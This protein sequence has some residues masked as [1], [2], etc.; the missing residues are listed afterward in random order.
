[1]KI[2][3]TLGLILVFGLLLSSASAQ[4]QKPE[5]YVQTRHSGS[6]NSTTVSK[7]GKIIATAGEDRT[8]KLFDGSNGAEIRT[9]TGHHGAVMAVAFSPDDKV[10]AT[11]GLDGTV[12][13]WDVVT[14]KEMSSPKERFDK[15]A[16]L[17]FSHDGKFLAIGAW[18]GVTLWDL[19]TNKQKFVQGIGGLETCCSVTGVAFTADSKTLVVV[20][21]RYDE[22]FIYLVNLEGELVYD[23][24]SRNQPRDISVYYLHQTKTIV[25]RR[26]RENAQTNE[27]KEMISALEFH[28]DYPP[29]FRKLTETENSYFKNSVF[30]KLAGKIYAN[31]KRISSIYLEPSG[32]FV[33][34]ER[35]DNTFVVWDLTKGDLPKQ[36]NDHIFS[37]PI[38]TADKSADENLQ[39]SLKNQELFINGENQSQWMFQK[40]NFS[41]YTTYFTALAPEGDKLAVFSI[42]KALHSRQAVIELYE[43]EKSSNPN[44]H[45]L[46]LKSSSIALDFEVEIQNSINAKERE[47]LSVVD[48]ISA[49]A[50]RFKDR[51]RMWRNEPRT[52][53][54]KWQAKL[55]ED[56]AIKIINPQTNTELCSLISFEQTDWAV[57]TPQ[58][59][60]DGSPNAWKQLI[61]RLDNNTFNYAPVEAFFKEFYYPG[62]LQEI[63]QGQTPQP[64]AKDL[65]EIDIRQPVVKITE[66]D[67]KPE[68]SANN[69]SADKQT[70]KVR[71]EIED[72]SKA[73]R[74]RDFPASSGANDL[75]LFRNGSLVKLWR[76]ETGDKRANASVFDLAEK[77]G[78]RQITAAKDRS[79]AAVCETEVSIVAG[80]NTFTAYAFNHDNIKSNDATLSVKRADAL[81]RPATLHVLAI[82][83]KDYSNPAFNLKYSVADAEALAAEIQKQQKTLPNFAEVKVTSLFDAQATKANILK[84]LDNLRRQVRPEDSVLVFFS[85][86]GLANEPRFYLIPYDLGYTGPR[87]KEA[88]TPR[89]NDIYAHGVSDEELSA[90]FEGIDA[91]QMFFIIDACNSG[92]ALE[93]EEKRR[94][95]MNSRGLAQLAYE[96]G[97]YI[98]TASQ[99]YQAAREASRLGHGYLTYALLEEGLKL[100]KADDEPRDGQIF[101]REW[102]NYATRRVP[103]MQQERMSGAKDIIEEGTAA[104]VFVEGDER[105][106]DAA[107]RRVQTPRVF[108][109]REVEATPLVVAKTAAAH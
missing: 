39:V 62:L 6:I 12:K 45:L 35:Q 72:N 70:V 29:G 83:I 66:I 78:C 73:G 51:W 64:P 109:R 104:V 94:G 58:G 24:L 55:A 63:L 99:S 85:G 41:E 34:A 76:K 81:K 69:I 25:F 102:F 4:K 60:F 71:I 31:S 36:S 96:K 87:T 26:L 11:G 15:I 93:A 92:Q 90:V 52:N 47:I 77:D 98:L 103:Q 107:K 17:A 95:P 56:G 28:E 49:F 30:E 59:L 74:I 53:D 89:L 106:A 42:G 48:E 8:A 91:G 27:T 50:P 67:G 105:V 97:M 32:K 86:H 65:S 44:Y 80:E 13:L 18:G 101:V 16:S 46:A 61:W 20:G 84:A 1:M 37:L 2:V 9:F 10:L 54:G 79:R 38:L 88:L 82:G 40:N 14:G 21:F 75:R 5:L 57:V 108:Y 23:G 68:S 43:I 33:S 7:N 22:G 19:M 100:G 3:K